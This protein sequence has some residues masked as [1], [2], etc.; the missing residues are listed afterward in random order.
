MENEIMHDRQFEL[1]MD[2]QQQIAEILAEADS[3]GLRGEVEMFAQKFI[4][5]DPMIDVVTAYDNAFNEWIK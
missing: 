3:W 2:Q 1:E 4:D 5:E